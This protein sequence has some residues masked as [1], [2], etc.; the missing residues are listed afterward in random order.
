MAFPALSAALRNVVIL[1]STMVANNVAA[2]P[3]HDP[4]SS[5]LA[6][7]QHER[8]GANQPLQDSSTFDGD[9]DDDALIDDTETVSY[10]HLTLPTIYSV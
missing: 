1:P 5:L 7:A 10:T 8:D 6:K 3:Y 4:A 9:D 2:I